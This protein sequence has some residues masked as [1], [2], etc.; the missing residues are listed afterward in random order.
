MCAASSARTY[1]S[2]RHGGGDEGK[3]I[4]RI[5][6]HED[7]K[8]TKTRLEDES[9]KTGRKLTE[10]PAGF[11]GLGGGGECDVL[12]VVF[13]LFNVLFP[14]SPLPLI[15]VCGSAQL[16]AA[17]GHTVVR[18]LPGLEETALGR[19]TGHLLHHRPAV[20]CLLSGTDGGGEYKFRRKKGEEKR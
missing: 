2:N 1:R 9:E 20:S 6:R 8:K 10:D 19:Q 12:S 11:E 13:S 14:L 17:A 3:E 4:S 15:S 7:E 5:E 16:P 18:R